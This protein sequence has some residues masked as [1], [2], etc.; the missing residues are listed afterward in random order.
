ML[1]RSTMLR[2]FGEARCYLD[3]ENAESNDEIQENDDEFTIAYVLDLDQ[4]L[5][6]DPP[7]SMNRET[8]TVT[9]TLKHLG[10]DN[11]IEKK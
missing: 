5:L 3:T 6:L 9:V 2:Q 10:L 1:K 4:E 8:V 7:P 11:I